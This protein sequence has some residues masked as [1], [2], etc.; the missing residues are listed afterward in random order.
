MFV[1]IETPEPTRWRP[2]ARITITPCPCC[3][4]SRRST[5][6]EWKSRPASSS[7]STRIPMTPKDGS[8]N[9]SSCRKSRCSPS[10]CCRRCRRR[11][12]GTGWR[13]TGGS[14]TT[15]RARACALPAALRRGGGDVAPPHRLCH[16]TRAAVHALPA[17]DRLDVSETPCPAGRRQAHLV[18]SVRA[19]IMAVRIVFYLGILA[20]Y[21]RPFW[22]AIRHAMRR[23]EIEA[24]FGIS[25]VPIISSSSRARRC[26]ASRTRRFIRRGAR[27]CATAAV[28]RGSRP[29][30]ARPATKKVQ[31]PATFAPT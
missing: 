2:C 4:R 15:R 18:E 19:A 17:S 9:S 26:V 20:D 1:G 27:D 12:Y 29:P 10:I 22:R 16:G 21:R 13:A 30:E 24:M 6:T 7:G 8:G 25:F 11:R 31:S 28:S 3:N 14:T 23:G 5:I